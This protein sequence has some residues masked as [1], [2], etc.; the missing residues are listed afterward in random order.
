M[1]NDPRREI[2]R[3]DVF[4]G[5]LVVLRVGKSRVILYVDFE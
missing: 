5:H 3:S 2:S 4:D 1:V